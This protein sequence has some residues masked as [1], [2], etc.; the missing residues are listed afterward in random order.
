M[1]LIQKIFREKKIPFGQKSFWTS[2]TINARIKR[3]SLV[4]KASLA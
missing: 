1:D 2:I 4:I 3:I